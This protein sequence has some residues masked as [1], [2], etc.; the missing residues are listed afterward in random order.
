[1]EKTDD[2]FELITAMDKHEKRFFKLYAHLFNHNKIPSYVYLFD[3]F[4]NMKV[5]DNKK[6]ITEVEKKI[7]DRNL[8]QLK[9]TLR[10]SI[11]S[12]L[13]LY[14]KKS[15]KDVQNH[16]NLGIAKV[17]IHKNLYN[18][19]EKI[20]LKLKKVAI[21]EENYQLLLL[22][23]IELIILTDK[24][25]QFDPRSLRL[26]DTYFRE[27]DTYLSLLDK[28]NKLSLVLA[29]IKL[30]K[31]TKDRFKIDH[32]EEYQDIL[33]NDLSVFKPNEI[34]SKN[35]LFA[36][37]NVLSLVIKGLGY[38][39]VYLETME[40]L[41]RLI[42]EEESTHKIDG[43]CIVYSNLLGAYLQTE[44]YEDFFSLLSEFDTFLE[45][46]PQG[47][48]K[49]LYWRHGRELEFY[50]LNPNKNADPEFFLKVKKDL[51]DPRIK[52][53]QIKRNGILLEIALYYFAREDYTKCQ[54]SINAIVLKEKVPVEIFYY[55]KVYLIE[56]I[57]H[58][59]L[60]NFE[61]AQNKLRSLER[62]LKKEN[63]DQFDLPELLK[64][65]AKLINSEKVSSK[66][67]EHLNAI[68]A[69]VNQNFEASHHLYI[70]ELYFFKI[71]IEKK[72]GH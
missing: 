57:S 62:K 42:E 13:K 8:G 37:Y 35:I 32:R 44:K 22:I 23:N 55:L 26:E 64:S 45:A 5:F 12:A 41:K 39:D 69:L 72:N 24:K 16:E 2:L 47:K 19:A 7:P 3:I 38:T 54:D 25:G 29:K 31:H 21:K 15:N 28:R 34:E 50:S 68:S 63:I 46:N 71:W 27:Y 53:S 17:L 65:L 33:Q 18:Q 36:Y 52:M 66:E 43:K 56:I 11:Y 67:K 20:L 60:S 1:M 30:I 61:I 14:H 48:T 4:S 40:N 49:F 51:K 10:T 9:K 6:L 70:G 58:Y 59:E